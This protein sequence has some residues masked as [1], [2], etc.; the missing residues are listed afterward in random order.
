MENKV[1]KQPGVCW[2]KRD[3]KWQVS[4]YLKSKKT[5]L[6]QFDIE[7][8]AINK[9]KEAE[10]FFRVKNRAKQYIGG[11]HIK[12][13]V[14]NE[15]D[16]SY[17]LIHSKGQKYKI[18][19]SKE[20]KEEVEKYNWYLRKNYNNNRYINTNLGKGKSMSLHRFILN[21]TDSI[22]EVDHFNRNTLDNRRE[23]LR[24]ANYRINAVN[25]DIRSNNMSGVTGVSKIKK[26]NCWRAEIQRSKGKKLYLGSFKNKED[27]INARK[28]AEKTYYKGMKYEG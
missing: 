5:A 20:D 4:I 25:C 17:F 9:R 10:L 12:T 3:K 2:N 6:G 24:L 28:E 21:I 14:Y 13:K 15:Y 11:I 8:D 27:A 23:N 1:S 22:I 26:T 16:Y 19:I 18:L 7:S